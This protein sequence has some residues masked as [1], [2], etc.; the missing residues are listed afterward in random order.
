VQFFQDEIA[1]PTPVLD[2]AKVLDNIASMAAK[3]DRH[4]LLLRPHFKTHQSAE[5]GQWFRDAGV[6]AITVSSPG[7]AATFAEAGWR[8]ITL[9]LPVHPGMMPALRELAGDIRLGL[10]VDSPAAVHA[11]A[12]ELNS[13]VSVWIKVDAGYGRAGIRW[14]RADRVAALAWEIEREPRFEFAGILAHNGHSYHADGPEGVVAVHEEALE[15]LAAVRAQVTAVIGRC[16]VSIGDTPSCRLA[17]NFEGVD[18]IRPGNFVFHD[19][20]QRALG[21]CT[22]EQIALAVACPVIGLYPDRGQALI[23]GG[24]IHF[25]RDF[26][27]DAEGRPVYGY[28]AAGGGLGIVDESAALRSLSQEHGLVDFEDAA[29]VGRLILGESLLIYPAHSCLAADLHGRYLT[30]D[31]QIIPK[32]RGGR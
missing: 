14:D 6:E 26:L 11:L 23:H 5:I 30:L 3:A 8:D 9:A 31:G 4:G 21:A 13:R 32:W 16:P 27:P 7:M 20:Q 10:L 17:D 22:D 29:R 28:M 1:R 12:G 24:A 2:T 18:E 19:L 15:R 25:S